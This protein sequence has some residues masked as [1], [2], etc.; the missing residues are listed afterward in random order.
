MAAETHQRAAGV[1][2][3]LFDVDGT[4]TDGTLYIGEGGELMK[5]FNA[6]DG[7]GLKILHESGVEVGLLSARTSAIVRARATELGIRTVLQGVTDKAGALRQLASERGLGAD[8]FGYM[9][10]D[11]PDLAVM[12]LCGFCATVPEAPAAV[13]SRAHY[14]SVAFGGR[15]AVR[16]VCELILASQGLIDAALARHLP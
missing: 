7:H 2:I 3:M 4:L 1:R 11:W 16:E 13:R 12:S 5:A 15:G 10:D 14:V 8:V 6:R 9:G